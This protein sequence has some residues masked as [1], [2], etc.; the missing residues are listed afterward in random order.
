MAM[1]SCSTDHPSAAPGEHGQQS[2]LDLLL[3]EQNDLSAVEQFA[4]WHDEQTSSNQNRYSALIPATSPAKGQ[5][6]AFQVDLESCSGCKACVVA[7]HEL[8]GLDETE[9][10]RDVGALCGGTTQEPVIQ[11]VTTACHHCLDPACLSACPVKAYEKDSVTGIVRHLDDQ[12]IGC[13]YCIFACPYDVPKYNRA[14]GIV[15][16]C[17]MCSGR[18]AVGEAPACV[19][20]CPNQ[21]IRI[22]LTSQE[23]VVD[24]CESGVF[25]PGAPDPRLTLPTTEYIARRALPRNLKAADYYSVRPEHAHWPLIVM[26]VLT[27]AAVGTFT[28]HELFAALRPLPVAVSTWLLAGGLLLQVM[29]LAASILH[30]GRPHL[31]YRAVLG[32]RTSWLSREI[33]AF[34]MFTPVAAAYAVASIAWPAGMAHSVLRYATISTGWLG[35]LCSAMVYI[36]TRREFWNVWYT[37][38]RFLLTAGLLGSAVSLLLALTAAWANA[39]V[40]ADEVFD[41]TG[42]YLSAAVI[43][44]AVAKLMVE[45]VVLRHLWT[46]QSSTLKRSALLL[47]GE[48]G[49][50]FKIRVICLLAGGLSLPMALIAVGLRPGENGVLIGAMGA[51][52]FALLLAGELAERYLFFTAVVAPKMPR[53]F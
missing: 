20:A 35:V 8:N 36:A 16:K 45:L 48:L 23:Q 7:C 22:T 11:H 29:A 50:V 41:A 19:Q 21:A 15:R 9:T 47:T 42:N 2:L 3:V 27:Q 43:S 10:W 1:A 17:D 30:L 5:Q 31:A 49:P 24:A 44:L 37:S 52:L 26:L 4:V 33:I 28:A 40:T 53:G 6:Y 38:A 51:L 32:V 46:R 14:K 18:L 39:G 12:C 25:L 34:G 13:Q